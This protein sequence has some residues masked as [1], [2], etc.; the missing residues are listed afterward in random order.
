MNGRV[1]ERTELV[2]DSD[3]LLH[4][5]KGAL[6]RYLRH[7]TFSSDST[8]FGLSDLSFPISASENHAGGID[9]AQNTTLITTV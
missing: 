2:D 6:L 7:H 8:L 4:G 5:D 1:N 9:T 3:M